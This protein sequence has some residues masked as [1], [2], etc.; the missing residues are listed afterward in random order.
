MQ[1]KRGTYRVEL[2]EDVRQGELDGLGCIVGVVAQRLLIGAAV[3]Q[4]KDA[5]GGRHMVALV[6]SKCLH[7]QEVSQVPLFIQGS[8]A[9][10]SFLPKYWVA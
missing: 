5:F 8:S 3:E 6:C 7:R 10:D 1:L 4:L 2:E 9:Q